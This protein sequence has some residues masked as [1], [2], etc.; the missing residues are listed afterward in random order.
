[1]WSLGVMIA[2]GME[3]RIVFLGYDRV[4]PLKHKDGTVSKIGH[5]KVSTY[6]LIVQALC[7]QSHPSAHI[8]PCNPVKIMP[9]AMGCKSVQRII[10]KL[11]N[12]CEAKRLQAHELLQDR[13]WMTL[14]CMTEEDKNVVRNQAGL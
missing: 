7:P 5:E 14:A 3:R 9:T 13:E 1:M 6:E 10:L 8:Q 11:L 4:T 2:D 12:F